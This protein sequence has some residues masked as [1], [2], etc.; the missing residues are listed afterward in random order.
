ML[1]IQQT[2]PSENIETFLSNKIPQFQYRTIN[3]I[4]QFGNND[5]K[6]NLLNFLRETI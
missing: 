6:Y 4:I 5:D 3:N 1:F 2:V